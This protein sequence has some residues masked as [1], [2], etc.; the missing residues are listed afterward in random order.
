MD[1]DDVGLKW[2]VGGRKRV[3]TVFVNFRGRIHSE[4]E[5]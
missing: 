3:L 5:I 4:G 2:R 1:G